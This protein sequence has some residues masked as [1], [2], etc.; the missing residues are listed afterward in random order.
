MLYCFR[1]YVVKNLSVV[2]NFISL[3]IDKRDNRDFTAVFGTRDH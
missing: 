1:F 3:N 2:E